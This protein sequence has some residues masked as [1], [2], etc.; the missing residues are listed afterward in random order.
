MRKIFLIVSVLF[1]VGLFF[2]SC[3]GDKP[4]FF[5]AGVIGEKEFDPEV[6]GKVFPL[7]Y[8][9]WL[10]T[11]EPKPSSLSMYRRDGIK[12]KLFMIS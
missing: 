7:Q 4:E 11:E 5:R 6:W 2:I 1:L 8:E 10:K 12:I 3:G 9:S